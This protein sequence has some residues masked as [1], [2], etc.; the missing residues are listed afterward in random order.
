MFKGF[1]TRRVVITGF[2]CA[3]PLGI[4][5]DV[6][7]ESLREGRSGTRTISGFDASGFKVRVAGEV[8]GLDIDSLTRS[9]NR[10]ACAYIGN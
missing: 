5:R 4:G 7:W 3:T 1:S 8:E 10:P 6:F 9:P 2:G